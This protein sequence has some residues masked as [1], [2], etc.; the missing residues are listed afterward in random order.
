MLVIK[1]MPEIRVSSSWGIIYGLM[2]MC[3]VQ[4]ELS[5]PPQIFTRKDLSISP[6]QT[7]CKE[8]GP[9]LEICDVFALN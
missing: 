5:I 3:Y 2:V 1:V 7:S 8:I 6:S 9:N 4:G